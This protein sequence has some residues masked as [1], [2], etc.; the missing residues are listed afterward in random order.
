MVDVIIEQHRGEKNSPLG[1]EQF[2]MR[3]MFPDETRAR[4]DLDFDDEVDLLLVFYPYNEKV[5][6]LVPWVTD[7]THIGQHFEGGASEFHNILRKFAVECGFQFKFKKN[8][9]VCIIVACVMHKTNGCTWFVHGRKLEANGFF[10]LRKC[11]TEH[12]YGVTFCTSK[13]LL[14][15]SELAGDI[16]AKRVRDRPLTRPT[17]VI[18]D[19]QQDYGLDITYCVAW[20]GVEKARGDLFGA[21]SSSFDQLRWYSDVVMEHNP[22]SYINMKYDDHTHSLHRRVQTLSSLAVFGRHIP[23][24]LV[25]RILA[26]RHCERRQPRF[27]STCIRSG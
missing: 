6:L 25:Q 9:S 5:F 8:D 27:I 10:N 14:V 11:N 26:R 15:G 18:L 13:N 3:L 2:N 12:I 16:M 4:T 19:L 17:E 23:Q 24:G 22:G 20:L 1:D 21:H 7:F